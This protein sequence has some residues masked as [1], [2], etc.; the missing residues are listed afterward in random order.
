MIGVAR[1]PTSERASV[2]MS[3]ER[4]MAANT[5]AFERF[6]RCLR[7]LSGA[8]DDSAAACGSLDL[9]AA[10][11]RQ[12]AAYAEPARAYHNARHIADCLVQLDEARHLAEEPAEI[13][14][15][16]WYHD[17]VYDARAK[18]NEVQSAR[19][20]SADL[21]SASV[22]AERVTRIA[23]L[24]LAT[25]HTG[26]PTSPD[27]ELLVDIDLSILGRDEASFAEY[28]RAIRAEYAWV[29]EEQYRQGRSAVLQK[30]LAR[31][32]IYSTPFFHERYEAAARRNLTAAIAQLGD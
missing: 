16:L 2:A 11:S 29:P 6:S 19:W 23:A 32:A 1:E 24:I 17:V 15:A 27:A 5:L 18:D 20:A 10:F 25:Q 22:P 14:A 30:F 9:R 7:A 26:E 12:Q 28:D 8:R 3:R 31:P 4:G 13:E 21:T